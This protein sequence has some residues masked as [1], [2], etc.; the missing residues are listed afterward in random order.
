[1]KFEY[2]YMINIHLMSDINWIII[3]YNILNNH[4]VI[5]FIIN[6]VMCIL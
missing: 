6:N 2:H 4:N 1:M 3:I 5:K